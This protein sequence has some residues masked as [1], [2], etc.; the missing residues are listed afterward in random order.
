MLDVVGL[1]TARAA[2]IGSL[3]R[4]PLI[5]TP[6]TGDVVDG[7]T[8]DALISDGPSSRLFAATDRV[9]GGA[10][11]L[12]FPK[13]SVGAV[14]LHHDAFVREAWA[15]RQ[16]SSPGV[17]RIIELPPGRQ[18]CLYTSMQLYD[19]ELLARRI[20]RRPAM[21]LEEA[22]SIA[23]RLARAA[24]SLHRVGIIHRD[25][26]PDN[27]ILE[28]NSLKLLDLGS[29]RLPGLEDDPPT[30][31]PGTP[32]YVAPEMFAGEPGNQSTDLYA[33][34]VTIF[35]ALTGEFP[36]G[37]LDATSR[38]RQDRPE[39][40]TLIRPDLPAWLHTVLARAIAIDPA[41]RQADMTE[42]AADLEAAPVHAMPTPRRLPTLYE[43]APVRVWQGIAALLACALL[44]S[45]VVR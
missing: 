18:T 4:L 2:E 26:K 5:P 10:L 40:L 38:P 32:A 15:G 44:A 17:V 23:I 39:D 1:P 35:Q 27:I 28:A 8:L 7:F 11:A 25:I 36:Y 12:K 37:N 29:V 24:S 3:R 42:F 33:L 22:T 31:I 21:T 6:N 14:G 30:E 9:D 20:D 13:P 45:L 19:G 16:V 34:G 43:R 41:G